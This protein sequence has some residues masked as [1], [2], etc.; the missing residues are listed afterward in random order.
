MLDLPEPGATTA[1]TCSVGDVGRA[2]A[3]GA[4]IWGLLSMKLGLVSGKAAGLHLLGA[5][6]RAMVTIGIVMLLHD[7]RRDR[8]ERVACAW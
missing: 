1:S 4:T 2:E 8:R 7:G 6:Y 3:A 5:G